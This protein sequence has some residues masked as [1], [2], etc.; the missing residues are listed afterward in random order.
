MKRT[1]VFFWKEKGPWGELFFE[2]TIFFPLKR[3]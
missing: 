1:F 2:Q 3:Q